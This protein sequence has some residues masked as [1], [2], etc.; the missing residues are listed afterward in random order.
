MKEKL[1]ELEK[2]AILKVSNWWGHTYAGYSGTVIRSD[3]ELYTY[4]YYH[5]IPKELEG[6]NVN[7]ITK[8]RSL[9]EKEFNKIIDFIEKEVLLNDYKDNMIFDAGY[10]VTVHYN[11]IDKVVRNN[12]GFGNDT[13]LYDKAQKIVD[14]L[15]NQS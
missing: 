5:R 14:D 6:K 8:K 12:K 3:K 15:I 10:D 11:G 9:N 2:R 13:G 4:Q 1:E 7:F